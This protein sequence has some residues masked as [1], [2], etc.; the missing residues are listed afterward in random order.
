MRMVITIPALIYNT[1]CIGNRVQGSFFCLS[2]ALETQKKKNLRAEWTSGAGA[3][4]SYSFANDA[5]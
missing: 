1:F 2:L 5:F 3:P 4:F